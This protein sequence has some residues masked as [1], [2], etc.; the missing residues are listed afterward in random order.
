MTAAWTPLAETTLS[1]SAS[2]VTF[3]SIPA[4]YRDLVLVVNGFVTS[5]FQFKMQFNG[6][7]SS[8]YSYVQM[9]A[10]P[11]AGSDSNTLDHIRSVFG[12]TGYPEVATLQIMDYSATDKHKT[13]LARENA[14]ANDW[15]GARASRWANTAAVTTI[16]LTPV[17]GTFA[18]G[19]TFQ[20]WGL[21][22]L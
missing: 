22:T 3:S 7:T 16:A 13:V 9:Y 8:S 2:S 18:S 19:S 10:A 20:L 11:T 6:D 14:I 17:S 4:G 1:S 12:G 15:V 5:N 21:N